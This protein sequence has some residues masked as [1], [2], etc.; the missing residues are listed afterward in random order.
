MKYFGIYCPQCNVW[1][2]D[3]DGRFYFYPAPEIA[4]A[5]I[6]GND[7]LNPYLFRLHSWQAQEFGVE[8]SI[9]PSDLP[10]GVAICP[11]IADEMN[12]RRY[13]KMVF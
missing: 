10:E 6:T 1:V 11:S 5:H 13:R 7:A 3:T 9:L 2:K 12:Q 4:N 8:R